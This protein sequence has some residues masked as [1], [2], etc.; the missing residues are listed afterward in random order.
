MQKE[1]DDAQQTLDTIKTGAIVA[2]TILASGGLGFAVYG[3]FKRNDEKADVPSSRPRLTK[4]WLRLKLEGWSKEL[5]PSS[6][7]ATCASLDVFSLVLPSIT[8]SPSRVANVENKPA[9]L[10]PRGTK[11]VSIR[12]RT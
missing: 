11:H 1:R 3:L 12:C 6:F 8:H 10:H 9:N 5:L 4:F 7:R 2:G